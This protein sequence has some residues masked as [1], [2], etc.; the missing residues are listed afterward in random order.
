M[1]VNYLTGNESPTAAKMNTLWAEADTVVAK[2]MDGK[3]LWFLQQLVGL[4]YSSSMGNKAR[5]DLPWRGIQFWVWSPIDHLGGATQ[6]RS[7]LYGMHVFGGAGVLPSAYSESAVDTAI[8]SA[9]IGASDTANEWAQTSSGDNV[10]LIRSLKTH[11]TV[12]SGTTCFLWDYNEPSP[13][14]THTWAVAEICIETHGGS[15]T[16]A[17]SCD[18]FNFFKIHNLKNQA[19]TFN[20]GSNYS[21]SVD[22]FSQVCVRRT[23]VSSGYDSSYKYFFKCNKDDPRWLYID[24]HGGLDTPGRLSH[25]SVSQSMRANNVTNASFLH[26]LMAGLADA[27]LIDFNQHDLLNDVTTAYFSAGV[28]PFDPRV[29]TGMR[30]ADLAYTNGKIGVIKR[31]TSGGTQTATTVDFV[32]FSTLGTILSPHGVTVSTSGNNVNLALTSDY[33]LL[34]YGLE[35]NL[36]TDEDR[37]RA[38][39]LGASGTATVIKTEFLQFLARSVS[40]APVPHSYVGI[41]AAYSDSTTTVAQAITAFDGVLESWVT[42]SSAQA[43][44]TTEG[45]ILKWLENWNYGPTSTTVWPI[46]EMFHLQVNTG[47]G[48]DM[49][50][51]WP[52]GLSTDGASL[53]RNGWPHGALQVSQEQTGMDS[54]DYAR[55][56][57]FEGPRKPRLYEDSATHKD[58]TGD[59]VAPGGADVTQG[60]IGTLTT[61]TIKAQSC[62]FNMLVPTFNAGN[63]DKEQM[64]RLVP[65]DALLALETN[66]A[67]ASWV[68]GAL[69]AIRIANG[70]GVWSGVDPGGNKYLRL[71]LLKEH[72]NDLARP[73]KAARRFAPFNINKISFP[74]GEDFETAPPSSRQMLLDVGSSGGSVMPIDAWAG[75]YAGDTSY[76]TP[77]TDIF[78]AFGVTIFDKFDMA[79]TWD[80]LTLSPWDSTLRNTFYIRTDFKWVKTVDVLAAAAAYNFKVKRLAAYV[81]L[82]L[83]KSYTGLVGGNVSGRWG[84]QAV[85]SG[86][87]YK[88]PVSPTR[89]CGSTF[90]NYSDVDYDILD[91][92]WMPTDRQPAL[93]GYP[94]YYVE[95]IDT[96]NTGSTKATVASQVVEDS[97]GAVTGGAVTY[98]TKTSTTF[99]LTAPAADKAYRVCI[100]PT[101]G[102]T[103]T[104]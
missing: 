44:L 87:D 22:A 78:T 61:S 75:W 36:F 9:T 26:S 32:G 81:P 19:L 53:F 38:P 6:D 12:V 72:F 73:V 34:L 55:H 76:N 23:S 17:D 91:P 94:A 60:D 88:K 85:S 33:V 57:L 48:L 14:K 46:E 11:T 1:A 16:L 68:N 24:S 56:R 86:A 63:T 77:Y 89:L 99:Y 103:H 10:E 83:E 47:G 70:T 51:F 28:M 3:S 37:F 104:A 40:A 101:D 95:A 97:S 98:S 50:S 66:K 18:K 74:T 92:Q 39:E 45:P 62:D 20:F 102:V 59:P 65:N 67:S 25:S 5:L 52:L 69:S 21:V 13:D 31:A 42:G 80:D 30:V 41:G 29:S 64:P 100:K 8:A 43:V 7:F 71:N 27:Q 35:T 82:K 96:S 15:Y 4:N 90:W 93:N 49:Q 54:P 79:S 2:A 58:F 84:L